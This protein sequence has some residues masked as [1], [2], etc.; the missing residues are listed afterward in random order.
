MTTNNT[1]TPNSTEGPPATTSNARGHAAAA[2]P[3][4]TT[5]HAPSSTNTNTNC[6]TNYN[7]SPA[8]NAANQDEAQLD[9]EA[10]DVLK[11]L[12]SLPQPIL[13]KPPRRFNVADYDEDQDA[14]LKSKA[15]QSMAAASSL[16]QPEPTR[17]A[18]NGLELIDDHGPPLPIGTIESQLDEAEWGGKPFAKP[19]SGKLE[20]IKDDEGPHHAST[21]LAASL[22]AT[23][24]N[25]GKAGAFASLPQLI[26]PKPSRPFNIADYDEGEDAKIK[27][28]AKQV[29]A[30]KSMDSSIIVPTEEDMA[31]GAALDPAIGRE[32]RRTRGDEGGAV[33][34]ELGGKV[35]PLQSEEEESEELLQGDVAPFNGELPVLKAYIVE[36]ESEQDVVIATQLE[37]ILPWWKQRRTKLLLGAVFVVVAVLAIALGVSL[38]SGGGGTSEVKTV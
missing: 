32:R 20:Q 9:E 3:S 4:P 24:E 25:E 38:S 27:S 28:E 34:L 12:A 22:E 15:K 29:D 23:N 13:P 2:A 21:A 6:N 35:E 30:S 5:V 26:L 8:A 17:Q 10:A 16:P 11:T 33:D 37:P 18:T 19:S 14:K 1:N 36:E 31:D 7:P